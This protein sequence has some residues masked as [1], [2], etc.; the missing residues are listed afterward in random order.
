MTYESI[1]GLVKQPLADL[2][3]MLQEIIEHIEDSETRKWM[4]YFFE[5]KGHELRPVLT[6]LSYFSHRENP[7]ETEYKM[8]ITMAAAF[9]LLHSASLVH[10]DVIDEGEFRRGKETINRLLNN[11]AAI[12]VGNIFYLEAFKLILVLPDRVFF[13]EMLM[14]SQQM[15]FGEISQLAASMES[16]HDKPESMDEVGYM[17]IIKKKTAL[18]IAL[19]MG[20]GARLAEA[21]QGEI[22]RMRET[23]L[24]F[25]MLYQL[26]DDLKDED[27]L[28]KDAGIMKRLFAEQLS[29]F[30]GLT[31]PKEDANP[32]FRTI[33]SLGSMLDGFSNGYSQKKMMV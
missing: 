12:L 32:Y 17:D 11:K 27:G 10:D 8:L 2:N 21:C 24:R 25:G 22:S 15:C 16:F 3:F 6:F 30:R 14:V 5:N 26:R 29:A 28:I 31:D 4:N 7:T 23:G 18:L 13:N 9:E 20:S 19:C 33:Q 1:V